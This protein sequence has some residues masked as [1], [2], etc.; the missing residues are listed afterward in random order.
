MRYNRLG[1]TGLYVSELCLGAMTFGGGETQGMWAAVGSLDQQQVNQIV[2]KSLDAGINFIDTANVYHAGRSESLVG[3]SL[4]DLGVARAEVVVATKVYGE[5]SP[6]PNGRGASRGHIMDQVEGS[7]KR[8]QTDHIDLY[9]IHATDIITPLDETLRALD[10]LVSRGMVR[11][12]GVSNW[13]AWRIA[14][15]LGI[16]E[17][18]GYARFETVQ[19]YYTIAGRDL[20]R[21]IVPLLEDEKLGLMVWSPLA[22]GL[23]S[24]KYGPGA[25]DPEGARRT[26]FDFPPVN[27]ERAWPV[28]AAMRE[29]AEKHGSSVARVALAWL[30][31][32]PVVTSVIIGAKTPEQLEDNLGA[33]SLTLDDEDL[34]KLDEVSRLP[35]EYPGWMVNFQGGSRIPKPFE[36]QSSETKT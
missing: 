19:S 35:P 5:M 31:S 22:G 23:L 33:V 27:R 18:R 14:K 21:D 20:E 32:R 25:P 7:L 10:D 12:V 36:P 16:S 6:G 9:Q 2:R 30:L 34:A 26:A 15:A 29:V 13:Q 24:G 17:R 4:K 11:Y 8:L 3:Q 28:I 1:R